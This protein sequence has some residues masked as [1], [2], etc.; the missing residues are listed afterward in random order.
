MIPIKLSIIERQMLANQYLILSYLE[1]NESE[2]NKLKSEILME[3]YTQGYNQVFSLSEEIPIEICKETIE[4][5]NMYRSIDN[6]IGPLSQEDK[7][8]LDLEKIQF[9]GFDQ[10]SDPHY[11]YAKF[12]IE[13][14]NKWDEHK[15][16]KLNS[17]DPFSLRKYK[18]M[19][20]YQKS[21]INGDKRHLDKND[22]EKMIALV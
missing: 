8:K 14:E 13:K 18:K 19:L 9:E 16:I 7:D 15:D 1:E 11:R 22:I 3:G 17:H 6:T 21:Q 20:D 12:M 4:I 2:L 10:Q 5:L